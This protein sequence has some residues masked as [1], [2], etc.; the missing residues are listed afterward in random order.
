MQVLVRVGGRGRDGWRVSCAAPVGTGSMSEAISAEHRL[1][2]KMK[3]IQRNEA[4]HFKKE[5]E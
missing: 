5:K 4:K 1:L 3:K 2:Q